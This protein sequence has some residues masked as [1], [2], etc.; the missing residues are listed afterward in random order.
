MSATLRAS[1]SWLG[2]LA[3]TSTPTIDTRF[4]TFTAKNGSP[5]ARGSVAPGLFDEKERAG[6]GSERESVE[7]ELGDLEGIGVATDGAWSITISEGSRSKMQARKAEA[8]V[9]LYVSTPTSSIT[10][11]RKPSEITEV[12]AR[13][14]EAFPTPTTFAQPVTKQASPVKKRSVLAS[15]TRTLSPRRNGSF[16]AFPP[17][18]RSP[19]A[20]SLPAALMQDSLK[21][22]A[23]ALTAYSHSAEVREHIAWEKFFATRQDDLRSARIEQRIK[24]HRSDQTLEV[25]RNRMS[26]PFD[27]AG[28]S[29]GGRHEPSEATDASTT[30]TDFNSVVVDSH[31]VSLVLEEQLVRDAEKL[32]AS[33]ED[34]EDFDMPSISQVVISSQPEPELAPPSLGRPDPDTPLLSVEHVDASDDAL[35]TPSAI[36][37]KD[38]PPPMPTD[39]ALLAPSDPVLLEGNDTKCSPTP[40]S[41]DAGED[42]SAAELEPLTLQP[43]RPSTGMTRSLSNHSAATSNTIEKRSKSIALDFFEMMRVLGKGCAGKVLL[44]REKK[45]SQL[46]A[47]K[48]ITKRHV[49]AHRELAH[50]R[51]EQSVLKACARDGL[52]PFVVRLHYSFHDEDTLYLAL[53]FHPG[54]DLATQL[55]RWGRLGRDRARFYI[56][57]IIEGVEGLHRAG[58]IY[59]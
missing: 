14:Y 32:L 33:R 10:L 7:D 17:T 19:T 4:K 31:P 2:S 26:D 5:R 38:G 41:P 53:D 46:M 8:Q 55:G 56:C 51:T 54:G 28:I 18:N 1:P 13:L 6:R 49:L 29:R 45:T 24:R 35:V 59:R 27:V 34:T 23:D 9:T 12:Y 20:A 37:G 40:A 43:A 30:S 48:A 39:A 52:N 50:T 42:S 36:D 21:G 3:Q 11:M 47:L 57:E 25:S 15:L 16:V 22:I 44:V 58:V